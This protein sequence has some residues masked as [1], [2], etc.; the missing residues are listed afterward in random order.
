MTLA[1]YILC[2][3]TSLWCCWLLFRGYRRS[4]VRLLFW[5]TWCFVGLSLN[6]LLLVIDRLTPDQDLST[7]RALP[8]L[9]GMLLLLWGMI[10]ATG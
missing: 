8:A 9:L 2:T 1:V 6:N 3:L 10:R 5:S 7:V 4:K